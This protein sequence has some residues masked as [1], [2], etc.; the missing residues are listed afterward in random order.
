MALLENRFKELGKEMKFDVII[1]NPPYQLSDGG[2]QASAKPIYQLFI[3]QA[4]KL[5]PNH[6]L[7]IVPSRWFAGGKGLDD[8]RDEMLNDERLKEIHDYPDAADCFNGVDIKGGVNYFHWDNNH[9]GDCLVKTYDGNM[10]I[11][12]MQRPLKEKNLDIFIRYNEGINI[13]RK[14]Q[15]L[16]EKSFSEMISA[17]KPFDLTTTVKGSKEKKV[18]FVKL[19]QNGGI[20]YWDKANI[21]K[22]RELISKH[23]VLV[24]YAIGVGDM[25][26]DVVKPIYAEPESICT[27]TYLVVASFDDK[28]QCENVISYINTKFFHFLLGLKKNTQHTTQK[29]YELIPMQD[30]SKHWTDQ[31]LYKKYKLNKKEI[32]FIE[33]MVRSVD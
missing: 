31:E 21:K 24:P 28:Q 5:N 22:N 15:K 27:E 14:I 8:F 3:Q 7:M 9:S 17:R 1:G 16:N 25:R 4:K 32:A 13:L 26:K 6:L 19:Y 33:K 23:K 10:C 11:S 30:F 29:V 2:A 20:A 18:G 12:S